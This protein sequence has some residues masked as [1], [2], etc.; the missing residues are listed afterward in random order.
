MRRAAIA[1]L[2]AAA[3]L[4]AAAPARAAVVSDSGGTLR[5][6]AAAGARNVVSFDE[7]V[8]G[9][10]VVRRFA[11]AQDDDAIAATGCTT[12]TAGSAYACSGVTQVIADAG[13]GA[14]V[15][16]AGGTELGGT[17]LST[18][19]ATLTG[20]DGSD[21]LSG[22]AG[23][24]V[25]DG[26]A[27]ADRL[28]GGAGQDR[29]AGGDGSDDLS[30]GA[31]DDTLTGGDEDDPF[32]PGGS[33]T[34]RG[35]AGDDDLFAAAGTISGGTGVDRANVTAV[36]LVPP[37][38]TVTLDG[39]ADDGVAGSGLN[40]LPDV[41][42]VTASA[43][44][45]GGAP[46]SVVL[47]GSAATNVLEAHAPATIVGGGGNDILTGS[48][49]NDTI[50]ARDGYADR[51]K[52][53]A[54]TDVALVDSVDVVSQD[55]E[56]VTLSATPVADGDH[57][58]TVAFT[59]PSGTKTLAPDKAIPL[60]V[61]AS[62]DRG[63]AKVQ[64]LDGDRLVCE[65][66]AAPFTCAYR[67]RGDDVGRDTL[68]AIAIDGAQQTATAVKPI[69][70]SRFTARGL[71]LNVRRVHGRLRTSGRLRMPAT[72]TAKQGCHGARVTVTAK[73]GKHTLATHRAKLSSRCGYH[74]TFSLGA[75]G[76]TRLTFRTSF[77]GNA[78]LRARS[79]SRRIAG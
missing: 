19:S 56:T 67:P 65:D 46:G 35:D 11:S 34:L 73:A 66:V 48:S 14:D 74:A 79:A 6:V 60:T 75:R 76:R 52:C 55:C 64:F 51:V 69:V 1:T 4:A 71:T 15:L 20:G 37:A 28:L 62:D 59:K 53:G 24:D 16:D 77:G 38:V 33:D 27:D 18:A 57:P 31:G 17:G 70:L 12:L 39:T 7:S 49:W 22:G 61:A 36:G 68:I 43:L 42:D 72:V 8:P 47:V 50:D 58:P 63:V 25:L 45:V 78:V 54:G 5:Y 41:E 32:A 23:D 40:V 29:L 10:V 44:G 2:V 3:A 9:T 30:G 21:V 13:N 26:G